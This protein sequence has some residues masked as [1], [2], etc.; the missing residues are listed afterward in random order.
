MNNGNTRL[1][2]IQRLFCF[3]VQANEYNDSMKTQIL[4]HLFTG[5]CGVMLL[6]YGL[7]AVQGKTPLLS[8]VPLKS[9]KERMKEYRFQAIGYG[10]MGLIALMKCMYFFTSWPWTE[11]MMTAATSIITLYLLYVLTFRV[12]KKGYVPGDTDGPEEMNR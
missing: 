9:E 10:G 8:V 5:L 6:G 1:L 7:L 3:H 4:I 12:Y 2:C 11:R